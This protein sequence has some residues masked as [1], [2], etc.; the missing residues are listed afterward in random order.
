[1]SLRRT[2][3]AAVMERRSEWIASLRSSLPQFTKRSAAPLVRG[4]AAAVIGPAPRRVLDEAIESL[5]ATSS[6]LLPSTWREEATQ[7]LI[8]TL[9]GIVPPSQ[10]KQTDYFLCSLIHPSYVQACTMRCQSDS[11][12]RR[13]QQELRRTVCMPLELTMTGSKSLRL[14]GE[15]TDYVERGAA[16]AVASARTGSIHPDTQVGGKGEDGGS[17]SGPSSCSY[18]PLDASWP[19]LNSADTTAFVQAFR[20]AGLEPLVLHDKKLFAASST[21]T[22]DD[23]AV[24]SEVCLAAF[25]ALCGSIELVSGWSSLLQ[26]V[27]RVAREQRCFE[28][29]SDGHE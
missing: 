26:F 8:T 18:Y 28:R 27:D 24:S 9:H 16:V 23:G 15:L 1:M 10:L 3:A 2:G 12:R 21:S 4:H 29:P 25:T 20:Q 13:V 14:L 7:Q 6:L 19:E 11:V 5:T 22:G 17:T